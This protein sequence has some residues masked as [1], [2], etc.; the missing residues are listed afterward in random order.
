M[1]WWSC[2]RKKYTTKNFPERE[3]N[4]FS[5]C[6]SSTF[7]NPMIKRGY[8][9]R[10]AWKFPGR[11]LW[12][13]NTLKRN[14]SQVLINFAVAAFTFFETDVNLLHFAI[15]SRLPFSWWQWGR[16]L[17]GWKCLVPFHTINSIFLFSIHLLPIHFYIRRNTVFFNMWILT[18]RLMSNA[19]RVKLTKTRNKC[20]S[21]VGKS[22]AKMAALHR[23][24]EKLSKKS[25]KI[26]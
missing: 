5:D 1:K 3:W 24:P 10:L 13:E 6:R 21:N 26:Q 17:I 16:L 8:R 20:R 7:R 18:V 9:E 4:G 25:F 14:R 15:F 11:K 19:T 2:E 12:A 22:V 23:F